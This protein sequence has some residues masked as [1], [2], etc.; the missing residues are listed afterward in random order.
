MTPVF[1]IKKYIFN[2]HGG[3]PTLKAE[4][5]N[6]LSF[7]LKTSMPYNAERSPNEL[8]FLKILTV[9]SQFI[10]RIP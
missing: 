5:F 1:Y 4:L 9:S 2:K 8:K 10:K 6:Q 3:T 7:N